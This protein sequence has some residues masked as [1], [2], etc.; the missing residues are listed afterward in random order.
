MVRSPVVVATVLVAA[1]VGACSDDD[2][3]PDIAEPTSS[4][5][6]SSATAVS[7][8]PT[9]SPSAGPREAV[10]AW[11][12]AWTVAMQTGNTASVRAL[13][14]P[15]CVSCDRLID[16]VEEVYGKGGH[17][18]TEGW[19]A[20]RLNEAP[21]SVS[22]TPSYIMQVVQA[23]RSLFGADGQLVDKSQPTTVPMRMTFKVSS[24]VW[25]LSRLEILE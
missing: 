9:V 2:P 11:L 18:E 25:T 24:D 19:T 13:S 1:L 15:G 21:D 3:K 6:S 10:G 22:A 5:P 7:T 12:A 14:D 23:S 8:P 17:Y 16:K 20:A 4:A